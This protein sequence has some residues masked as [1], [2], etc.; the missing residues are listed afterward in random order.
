MRV[1]RATQ[2]TGWV[3]GVHRDELLKK[4]NQFRFGTV[5]ENLWRWRFSK[6]TIDRKRVAILPPTGLPQPPLE[7]V[8]QAPVISDLVHYAPREGWEGFLLSSTRAPLLPYQIGVWRFRRHYAPVMDHPLERSLH[9]SLREQSLGRASKSLWLTPDQEDRLGV[10]RRVRTR[11][12][13][14]WSQAQG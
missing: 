13:R 3:S 12:R 7:S 9:P 1:S 8:P 11:D 2:L 4:D 10:E 5:P 14:R 6:A